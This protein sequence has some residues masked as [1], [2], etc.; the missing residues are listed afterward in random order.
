MSTSRATVSLHE[1]GELLAAIPHLL[2]FY[3]DNSLIAVTVGNLQ[4][5]PTVQM[6]LRTDIPHPDDATQLAEHVTEV[7]V[8]RGA[9][10]VVLVI[11]DSRS[12]KAQ[13]ATPVSP[14]HEAPTPVP[15][16][17]TV[18]A[19]RAALKSARIQVG[20]ATWI[21]EF[22]KGTSWQCYDIPEYCGTLPD[23]T[24]S[25]VAVAMAV[26]GSM[27][28]ASKAD[29]ENSL[30]SSEPGEGVISGINQTSN[31]LGSPQQ[32]WQAILAAIQA[33][34]QGK[35]LDDRQIG[36]LLVVLTD[37]RIRDRAL[38]KA[39]SDDAQ[40]AMALW[41]TLVRNAPPSHLADPAALLAFYS[42]LHGDGVMT[43]AALSRIAH[44]SDP[45]HTL[46]DLLTQ[47]VHSAVPPETMA[48]L[49]QEAAEGAHWLLDDM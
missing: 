18:N 25:P 29:L 38:S 37:H 22:R 46:G 2:G 27:T 43:N 20:H 34:A 9:E 44:S 6:I 12:G 42:Y 19:V 7:A 16:R 8:H 13:A 36:R 30:T 5:H 21:R 33:T 14:N 17:A 1:R 48:M 24:E 32:G 4:K 10:A 35:T 15:H 49:A 28:H 23:P 45:D 39:V 26:S 11:A 31:E 3:P 47:A 40:A 41:T